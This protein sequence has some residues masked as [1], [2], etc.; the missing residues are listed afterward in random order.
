[1]TYA[2]KYAAPEVEGSCQVAAQSFLLPISSV[3]PPTSPYLGP[4]RICCVFVENLPCPS[5]G[6]LVSD[7][8]RRML[9]CDKAKEK[10]VSELLAAPASNLWS[11]VTAEAYS[12]LYRY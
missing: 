12:I 9:L 11:S 3:L 7:M 5:S 6:Q 10:R 8:T 1:M 4:R 2:C